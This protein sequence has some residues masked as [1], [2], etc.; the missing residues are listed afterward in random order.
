[1]IRN[2]STWR[3]QQKRLQSPYEK[4]I[5]QVAEDTHQLLIQKYIELS[6][7]IS[8]LI[9][10]ALDNE[11][12]RPVPFADS[13]SLQLRHNIPRLLDGPCEQELCSIAKGNHKILVQKC[14]ESGFQESELIALAIENELEEATPFADLFSLPV[15]PVPWKF[16]IDMSRIMMHLLHKFPN[17]TGRDQ[18][19][20]CRRDAGV[21]R[22]DAFL[23][24]YWELLKSGQIK[25]GKPSK[26]VRFRYKENYLWVYPLV[27]YRRMP[28]RGSRNWY[29]E[30]RA[31]VKGVR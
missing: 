9:V 4:I 6:L 17:G 30:G 23:G 14:I 15:M 26:E 1:M 5:C 27:P 16:D 31:G 8:R 22:R 25:E 11:L 24:A 28:M 3:R 19:M 10:M 7:P 20:L 13:F 18:L 29:R 21:F 2:D 12:E